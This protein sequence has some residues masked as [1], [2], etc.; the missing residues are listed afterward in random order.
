V[1]VLLL[2]AQVCILNKGI[3]PPLVILPFLW[4][5]RLAVSLDDLGQIALSSL[6]DK[7]HSALAGNSIFV[8][9]HPSAVVIGIGCHL[10]RNHSTHKCPRILRRISSERQR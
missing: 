2:L 9:I 7:L 1:I 5:R 10:I 4:R 3:H 6:D 8:P